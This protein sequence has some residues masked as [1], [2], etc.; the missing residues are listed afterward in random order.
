VAAMDAK[1]QKRYLKNKLCNLQ[2]WIEIANNSKNLDQFVENFDTVIKILEEA[3]HMAQDYQRSV[4]D[5]YHG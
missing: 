2:E 1:R 5:G 3:A 4:G